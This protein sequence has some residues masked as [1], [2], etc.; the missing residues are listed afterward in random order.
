MVLEN[1]GQDLITYWPLNESSGERSDFVGSNN[2]TDINTVGSA[3]GKV[4]LSADFIS[5]NSEALQAANTSVHDFGDEDFTFAG[6]FRIDTGAITG[7]LLSKT[8]DTPAS[9][10]QYQL[11]YISGSD[12]IRWIVSNDGSTG[13]IV[14]GNSH[15]APAKDVFLFVICW[16]DSINDTINIQINDGTVDSTATALGIKQG[17]AL[18]RIGAHG[19]VEP[20]TLVTFLDGRVDELAV[21]NRVLTSTE[22]SDLYNSGTGVNLIDFIPGGCIGDLCRITKDL[23][24]FWKLEESSGTRF[25]FANANN[26]EDINTVGQAAGKIDNAANLVRANSEH[27]D[28]ADS[29]VLNFGDED[30]TIAFWVKLTSKGGVASQTCVGKF[31]HLVARQYFADYVDG[32]TDR[33]RFIVDSDGTGGTEGIAT[34]NNFGSPTIGVFHFVIV[35]HDSVANTINIQVDDGTPN[36]TAYSAGIFQGSA[37]FSIGSSAF[38]DGDPAFFLNGVIDE[39]GVWSRLLSSAEKTALYNSGDGVDINDFFLRTVVGGYAEGICDFEPIVLG[40]YTKGQFTES[41]VSI[42]GFSVGTKEN[43]TGPLCFITHGNSSLEAY[44]KLEESAG[45]R[46]DFADNVNLTDINTV[47][48]SV[49]IVGSGAHFTRANSETLEAADSTFLNFGDEDFTISFWASL[50]TK[51][52]NAQTMVSKFRPPDNRQYFVDFTVGGGERF[53]FLV[54]SDGT[55]GTTIAFAD[56]LGTPAANTLYFFV[57]WHDSVANTI[58][59]QIDNG[60]IDSAAHTGG[61]FQGIAKF[62]LGSYQDSG[63]SPTEFLNGI[64]DEVGVWSR[65]LSTAEK[66]A[67]YNSGAGENIDDFFLRPKLGGFAQSV[68]AQGAASGF[69]GGYSQSQG[70]TGP[71]ASIGGYL[72]AEG[73][74]AGPTGIIGGFAESRGFLG[75]DGNVGG[76]VFSRAAD[77]DNI[78]AILGGFLDVP[79]TG[80]GPV[81]MGGFALSLP[82]TTED[83]VSIGGASSGLFQNQ[84]S[85][86]GYSFGQPAFTNFVA[87]R[88]RTLVVVTSENV[89]G[90]D[91]N[92][93]AQIVFKA[94]SAGDFNAKLD[95]IKT[96]QGDVIAAVQVEKFQLPPT[97]FIQ[98]VELIPASGE[99]GP[100]NTLSPSG[101]R[102]VCVTAS[103]FLNDGDEFVSAHIDFAD[104]FTNQPGTANKPFLSVSGFTGPPPWTACHDYDMSGIYQIT[105]RAQDNRGMV[106]MD[107]S[108]IALTSGLTAGIHYPVVSISGTPRFGN[109]PPSMQ[110]N[111]TLQSSGLMVPPFTNKESN[112]SLVQ[113]PTDDRILWQFGN[114]ERSLKKNPFTFYQSPGLFAP[115]VMYKLNHPSGFGRIMVS[116]SLLIGFVR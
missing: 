60:G 69:L 46:Y 115:K 71:T 41:P 52:G 97:V 24:A 22:K 103:G 70:L 89:A 16:H 82:L 93:D 81:A 72:L 39:V 76:F 49:A 61:A 107:L 20:S 67:L 83:A 11:Q 111:F 10:A 56:S 64:V 40:G 90:Q 95:N 51:P 92:I 54:D 15:G 47:D 84:R 87:T 36:S 53:R 35:W 85:I 77:D 74:V 48:S 79:G 37:L 19:D 32:G 116:D 23:D 7:A 31:D 96:S 73:L 114:R 80:V 12:R 78:F 8:T 2:L 4:D 50:D 101:A 9:Q 55:S 42:G 13:Q 98:S 5:A 63:G 3:A 113:S 17:T 104:P 62:A 21:W 57:V 75:P 58:N 102:Q 105:A 110:V 86:G 68:A 45:T 1:I 34:A 44:W 108:G 106:G 66:T 88:G 28:A 43:C 33:F 6:W 100:L 14:T 26:L 18:F 112:D 91:L 94:L 30:F 25:D 59:I 38:T 109:I 65:L 99:T 29:G 27:L